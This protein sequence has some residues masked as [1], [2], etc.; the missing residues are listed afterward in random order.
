MGLMT[1]L[2]RSELWRVLYELS[3]DMLMLTLVCTAGFLLAE[4]ILPGVFSQRVNFFFVEAW[5]SVNIV[6][7]IFLG[8]KIAAAAESN[9]QI[10]TNLF[11][12]WK[13]FFG[14]ILFF[15]IFLFPTL[16]NLHGMLFFILLL[17]SGGALAYLSR[18]M[19]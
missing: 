11:T 17:C 13:S 9:D 2:S 12:G 5:F 3:K 18:D 1:K 15:A 6:A 4:L 16:D 14:L 10:E 19:L 7:V 8:R